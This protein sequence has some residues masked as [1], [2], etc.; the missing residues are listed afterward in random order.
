[1]YVYTYT[2]IHTY[3]NI[4]YIYIPGAG[5]SDRVARRSRGFKLVA[6]A[7]SYIPGAGHSERV[8]RRSPVR[9]PRYADALRLHFCHT[10]GL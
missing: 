7:L 5:H 9:A 2:Y 6:G 8:A 3:I 10:A 4:Y 1:M